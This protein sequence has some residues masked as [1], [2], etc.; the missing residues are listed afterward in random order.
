[1]TGVEPQSREEI[2]GRGW[3]GLYRSSSSR[4]AIATLGRELRLIWLRAL[5]YRGDPSKL[6]RAL[7]VRVGEDCVIET[8]YRNFGAQ[9]WLIELGDR[10]L[11]AQDA[12]FLTHDGS[13]LLF[14]HR[15]SDSPWGNRFGPIKV[16]DRSFIGA[17][18]IVLPD[19]EIGPDSI[20]G[21]G[22]VVTGRI[23]PGTVW[24]GVPARQL[25]TRAEFEARYQAKMVP[26][27]ARTLAE[28]RAEL[29]RYFFGEPR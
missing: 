15:Y 5:R 29:T 16:H 12:L 6:L 13:N 2:A 26:A 3:G 14:R 22:S 21:A 4:R 1:V 18:A 23:P 25:C 10:V 20:V 28:L 24:A 7:G 19:S 17:R 9:P 8:H 11:I 27:K